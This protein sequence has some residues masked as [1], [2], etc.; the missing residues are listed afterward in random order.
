[1]IARSKEYQD[2]IRGMDCSVRGC[3]SPSI[4]HH[5]LPGGTG[6]KGSD[7]GTIPL[8]PEHHGILHQIGAKTFAKRHDLNYEQIIR[9]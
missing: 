4:A 1:M 8:C 6:L 3:G 7:F 5:V 9:R 2:Y